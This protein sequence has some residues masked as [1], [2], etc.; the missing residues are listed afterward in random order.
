MKDLEQARETNRRLNRRLQQMEKEVARARRLAEGAIRV[1]E[2]A[3]RMHR[4]RGKHYDKMA[5][6]LWWLK[7]SFWWRIR[8]VLSGG[9]DLP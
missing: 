2:Y 4:E 9:K 8:L 7:R 6:V 5:T 3:M 1:N